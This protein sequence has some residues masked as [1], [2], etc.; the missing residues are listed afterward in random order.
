M[1]LGLEGKFWKGSRESVKQGAYK[2]VPSK[3]KNSLGGS[4]NRSVVPCD[5]LVMQFYHGERAII[6]VL[7]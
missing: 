6:A 1:F 3:E 4:H 2:V 5:C 7:S